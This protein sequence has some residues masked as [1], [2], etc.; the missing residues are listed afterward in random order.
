[1]KTYNEK[2]L[3]EITF[4]DGV[5]LES[6]TIVADWYDEGIRIIIVRGP[7]SF[8]C[9]IGVPETHPLAGHDYDS[10]SI[11]CHGGL[12]YSGKGDDEY[13]PKGFWWYGWDYSHLG[14]YSFYDVKYNKL[15]DEKK[16]TPNVIKKDSWGAIYD[17]KK[18]MKL[19][20]KI[21]YNS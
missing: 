8:N 15:S 2:P 1:M 7:A 20:E 5:G 19:A 11:D 12:T 6:S 10:L 16:W 21:K 18:L 17:F 3:E 13:F 14:D 9:Y 4:E